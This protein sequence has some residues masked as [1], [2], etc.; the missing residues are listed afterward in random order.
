MNQE[1]QFDAVTV[2]S[3]SSSN[4]IDNEY[5]GGGSSANTMSRSSS[6]NI[7][8]TTRGTAAQ[9]HVPQQQQ[10]RRTQSSAPAATAVISSTSSSGLMHSGPLRTVLTPTSSGATIHG[11]LLA[12]ATMPHHRSK[13]QPTSH[14]PPI[15]Q[16]Q[17]TTATPA[18][19]MQLK[20]TTVDP[21][22]QQTAASIELIPSSSSSSLDPIEKV[23]STTKTATDFFTQSKV[24]TLQPSLPSTAP[25]SVLPVTTVPHNYSTAN[26][27]H[28]YRQQQQQQQ[29][30][31]LPTTAA[32][33]YPSN[34]LVSPIAPSATTSIALVPPPTKIASVIQPQKKTNIP[35]QPRIINTNPPPIPV[36]PTNSTT[37]VSSSVMPSARSMDSATTSTTNTAISTTVGVLP[38]P[39]PPQPP[40]NT[41]PISTV[42]QEINDFLLYDYN[43]RITNHPTSLSSPPLLHPEPFPY[44]DIDNTDVDAMLF[45]KVLHFAYRRQ[46][47]HVMEASNSIFLAAREDEVSS[48]S[49]DLWKTFQQLVRRPDEYNHD[50]DHSP[51]NKQQGNIEARQASLLYLSSHTPTA[52]QRLQREICIMLCLRFIA[53]VK[54]R[55]YTQLGHEIDRLY[56]IPSTHPTS[57]SITIPPWIPIGLRK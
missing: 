57:K 20:P 2:T 23:N 33:L 30:S 29:Q 45:Q 7:S 34:P 18:E 8:S 4:T 22:L 5:L 1:S 24:D 49:F 52:E 32:K 25:P 12:S 39:L 44:V 3:S 55:K 9:H 21:L 11:G 13:Q 36:I 31:H 43:H 28:H 50:N 16:Q 27:H 42:D 15:I 17:A 53:L 37:N 40:S 54:L 38:L 35:H 6:S 26:P 56:L 14:S 19:V 41:T 51:N 10:G 48:S 47:N 46:W